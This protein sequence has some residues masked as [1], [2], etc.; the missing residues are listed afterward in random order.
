MVGK[1]GNLDTIDAP[2]LIRWLLKLGARL[3]GVRHCGACGA[4]RSIVAVTIVENGTAM[5]FHYCGQCVWDC[6]PGDQKVWYG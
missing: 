5:T 1:L 3:D 6:R 4:H 2:W